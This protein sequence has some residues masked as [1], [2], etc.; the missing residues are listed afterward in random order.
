[1]FVFCI[2]NVLLSGY[3]SFY[4]DLWV[5][6]SFY[7]VELLSFIFYFSAILTFL[8]TEGKKTLYRFFFLVRFVLIYC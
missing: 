1:M 6:F 7:L 3:F 4:F 5:S 8:L 2:L